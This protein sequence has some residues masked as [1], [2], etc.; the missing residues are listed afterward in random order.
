M[1]ALRK[2]FFLMAAV[3]MLSA[4]GSTD[5]TDTKDTGADQ[6]SV[7]QLFN[8]SGLNEP[9][10][11]DQ[12]QMLQEYDCPQIDRPV[13]DSEGQTHLNACEAAKT[14]ATQWTSGA[15]S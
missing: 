7:G 15:C 6:A 4:C 9:L 5:G 1:P 3:A 2:I 14:G 8:Q 11:E 10:T 12:A 13:C